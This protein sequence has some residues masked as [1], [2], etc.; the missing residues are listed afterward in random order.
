MTELNS[1]K[2]MSAYVF[3]NKAFLCSLSTLKALSASYKALL[4]SFNL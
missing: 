2:G 4:Y 1:P 3:L